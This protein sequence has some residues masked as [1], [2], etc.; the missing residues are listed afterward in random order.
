MRSVRSSG[1]IFCGIHVFFKPIWI[2]GSVCL[3]GLVSGRVFANE[4]HWVFG[5]RFGDER[6]EG[7]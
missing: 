6:E 1:C 4:G 3:A 7:S 2:I 5:D